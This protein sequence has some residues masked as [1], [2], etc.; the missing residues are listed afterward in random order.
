MS[1]K[2]W[3]LSGMN[4]V[5]TRADLPPRGAGAR[6]AAEARAEP[7]LHSADRRSTAGEP[8]HLGRYAALIGAIR[9]ELEDFVAN[10]LRL[11]LAIA[12]RD[13]FL[14]T[15]IDVESTGGDEARELLHRFAR[16]FTPEQV[17]QYLAREVIARLPNAHAIDLSQFAGLAA[18]RVSGDVDETAYDDLMKELRSAEPVKD[19]RPYHVTLVGRWAE[20]DRRGTGKTSSAL[21]TPPTPLSGR[22]WVLDVEDADGH[23]AIEL[24][25][26]APGRR[27]AV[28]KD[29][30][31]D[32]VVNGVYASRRHCEIWLEHGAWW[33]TDAGS[34]NG[35]RVEP[36]AGASGLRQAAAGAEV[37][38]VVAD[39]RIVLSASAQGSTAQYPRLS[40]RPGADTAVAQASA[41][42]AESPPTPVTPIIPRPGDRLVLTARTVSG[43]RTID[44]PD[45]GAPIRVGRSRTQTLVIDWAHQ[46]V[47]GHH[48]DI[49][50][51]DASGASV[52]VHGDNGVNVDGTQHGAGARFHWKL[53]Q[54][55]ILGRTRHQEPEC[56]L[57]LSRR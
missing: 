44:V 17:R 27:Y 20:A 49:L 15:S 37:L 23:R 19:V 21:D 7:M 9:E 57:T 24:R 26:V 52:V 39:A 45:G 10:R 18:D 55:V 48:L 51:R 13:R 30:G 4:R 40:I 3:M 34:T 56:L 33:V 25:A 43:E 46:G 36:P 12:E 31:C 47:S 28:G 16:E 6:S 5:F 50:D 8:Q 42:R 35:L 1:L 22:D 29:D 41:P 32:I 11:H 2:T 54:T 38:E 53:G 14:L